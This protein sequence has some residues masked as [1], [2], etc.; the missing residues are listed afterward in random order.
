MVAL[1][2]YVWLVVAATRCQIV[3]GQQQADGGDPGGGGVEDGGIENG[4]DEGGGADP[5][6]VCRLHLQR[7]SLCGSTI[8]SR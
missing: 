1:W 3:A 2:W 7:S 8:L 5:A 4:G 6:G